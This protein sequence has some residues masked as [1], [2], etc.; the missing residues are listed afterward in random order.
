MRTRSANPAQPTSTHPTFSK[1]TSSSRL[2]PEV[3]SHIQRLAEEGESAAQI[4]HLRATF[5]L[6]NKEWYNMVDY[7]THIVVTKLS[8]VTKLTTKLRSSRLR[9][10]LGS[11]TKSITVECD[12]WRASELK[13]LYG[14]FRWVKGAES[15][16][17]TG[18]SSLSGLERRT[19]AGIAFTDAL[20][21]FTR[22]RHFTLG[23]GHCAADG[24]RWSVIHSTFPAVLSLARSS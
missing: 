3:I 14:L 22:L 4:K 12:M 11:K 13:K 5:E 1:P 19:R 9:T 18:V 7:F 24:V 20:A 6:V 17:L 15:V 16:S 21:H 2:P 8:D 23:T 10:V